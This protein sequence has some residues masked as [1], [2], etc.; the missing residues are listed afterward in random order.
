MGSATFVGEITLGACSF[1]C[2]SEEGGSANLIIGAIDWFVGS[3]MWTFFERRGGAWVLVTG[4]GS[5]GCSGGSM[6]E[7]GIHWV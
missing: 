3:E 5:C 6:G 7:L 1:G 4:A 2:N